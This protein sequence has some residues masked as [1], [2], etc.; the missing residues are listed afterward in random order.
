[1]GRD[2]DLAGR[3]DVSADLG[4]DDGFFAQA[5]GKVSG[6]AGLELAHG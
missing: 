1:V 5:D 2:L 3:P 6:N 4:D